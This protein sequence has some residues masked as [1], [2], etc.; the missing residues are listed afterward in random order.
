MT[1]SVMPE[2]L[3]AAS[4]HVFEGGSYTQYLWHYE[5]LDGARLWSRYLLMAVEQE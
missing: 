3:L 4:T 2:D 5:S 1:R